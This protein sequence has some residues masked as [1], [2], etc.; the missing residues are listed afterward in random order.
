MKVVV[1]CHSLISDWNHGN[2]HFLRGLVQELL[3]S[4]VRVSVYEPHDSWSLMNL[5]EDAGESMIER[6]RRAYPSLDSTRYVEGELDL[7]RTLAGA[8]IVLVH[9]WNSPALVERIGAHHARHPNYS[10]FFHDTHHRSLTRPD[11]MRNYD[12]RHYDAVLAF[13]EVIRSK[14]LENGWAERAYT[15][16][17]AADTRTFRP[18]PGRDEDQE[19]DLVW[20]GNFG[21]EER[22]A[23]LEEFLLEP[24]RRLGLRAKVYGV[25]YPADVLAAL[26]KA[27]IEYGGYLPNWEVPR[28]FARYRLTVHVPRRP[29]AERLPG[30]PTIR[31]FEAMSCGIPMVSAPWHDVEGLFCPGVDYL[32]ARSGR[33]MEATLSRLLQD[34]ALRQSLARS[35]RAAIEARHTCAH[36]LRALLALH[37]ELSHEPRARP[38]GAGSRTWESA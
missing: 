28:V 38:S 15:W 33:E 11:E 18:L 6:F 35:G 27:G 19:G 5:L 17:E 4:G 9:E 8:D 31:P 22:R 37:G 24:V 21:D 23:E 1:F 10:L 29:Y 30:I 14:Y 7:E 16:H 12:L 32:V 34:R 13:G 36:R 25:R 20:V 2:A 26:A 3:A